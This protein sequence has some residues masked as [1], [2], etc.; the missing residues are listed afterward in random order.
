[1]KAIGFVGTKALED[2]TCFIE[3]ETPRPIPQG[4]DIL[5]AI[6]AISVNPV[7]TKVRQ[8]IVNLQ[9]PAKILGWDASGIVEAI[10]DQVTLFKPGDKVFYAGDINRPGC[11]AEYQLVDERI[12]GHQPKNLSFAQAAALPLTTIT[13]WEALFHRLKINPQEE[14][15]KSILIIGAAGGVGSIAIQIA[16]K[17]ANLQVIAT[18]SR[19]ESQAWC[20]SLGAD[21]IINHHHN[22]LDIFKTKNIVLPDYIFCL[23]NPDQHFA[24]MAELIAPQGMICSILEIKD[25]SKIQLL[26]NKSAGL[27]WEFMFT[28]PAAQTFDMIKQHELLNQTSQLI[29]TDELSTTLK[30]N[31]GK[32]TPET[33]REAH[34]L[35]E[36]GRTIGKIVLEI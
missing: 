31:L 16:K 35:L 2:K 7:D 26:K 14:A 20:L 34:Q 17:V 4:H 11:N 13:A 29:E 3:F 24:S 10:G 36:T 27:V 30:T 9:E 6:K 33:L 5:V 28:R 18:A 15:N 32:M 1:M 8:K 21:N 23:N 19:Q 12:A 22:M 25:F